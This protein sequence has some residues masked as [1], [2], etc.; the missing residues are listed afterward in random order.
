MKRLFDV[1]IAVILLIFL[2]I[3]ILVLSILIKL[4][5]KGSVLYW[6]E[7]VGKNN[8]I[9]RMPIPVKVDYDLHYLKNRSFIFDLKILMS[10]L[11]NVVAGKGVTH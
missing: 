10:T 11:S 1:T 6:S 5:S 4:T 2:S 8:S 7:R 3:P 9:F